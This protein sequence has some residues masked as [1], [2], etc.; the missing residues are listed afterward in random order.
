MPKNPVFIAFWGVCVL[1]MAC[2]QKK[3]TTHVS[4]S[5][6]QQK[7]HSGEW[8]LLF[9]LGAINMPVCVWVNESEQV[10]IKNA[11]EHI[12][13]SNPV[14]RGDS[15]FFRAPIF[16]NEFRGHILSSTRI[17]GTWHNLSKKNYAISFTANW[18]ETKGNYT[19]PGNDK[20]EK[21]T[22]AAVFSPGTDDEYK[23]IGVFNP[24]PSGGL[25]HPNNYEGTFMT[26]TGDYRYLSGYRRND[27]L[28][29]AAFDGSHV[30]LFTAQYYSKGD[31]LRGMF[32][33][34][35]HWSEPW[36]AGKNTRVSLSNPDSLTR[37]VHADSLFHF[38]FPDLNGKQLNY[39][40]ATFNNK[41][42]IVQIMG[43]W[44]PNC[45][46]E[47]SYLMDVYRKFQTKGVEVVSLCFERSDDFNTSVK[48]VTR[49][50]ESLH[51]TYP[52]LIAG[53]ANKGQAVKKLPMLNH[54]MSFP[55]TVYLDRK[56]N[57][58]KIY[59]GFYGPST[60]K[61]HERFIEENQRFIEKL[62]AE[63]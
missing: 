54:I 52:F 42:T 53:T 30:F 8:E 18:H 20:N 11:S 37:M 51:V 44:C 58:R 32:Y 59:T 38:S 27:S 24:C 25:F 10:I 21:S 15:V 6:V 22:W 43:S 4:E 31:S 33:S 2:H 26:E 39:P 3:E 28:L 56:G 34:G 12:I 16:D 50:K 5:S 40:S 14:F 7:I 49:M 46:D 29:L 62:L 9:H 63:Q 45:M 55:T 19:P 57:V 17:T 1:L 47:T 13:C 23:A 36:I 48:Q 35:N 61:Y 41:V 60:G